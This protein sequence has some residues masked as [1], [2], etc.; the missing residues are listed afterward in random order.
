MRQFLRRRNIMSVDIT[1]ALIIGRLHG[2]IVAATVE[3]IV[4]SRPV[5]CSVYTSY[6][7]VAAIGDCCA[8]DRRNRR[9]AI[10]V[11]MSI[12][13]LASKLP[14]VMGTFKHLSHTVLSCIQVV[15]CV[16]TTSDSEQD[17]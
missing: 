5:A 4:A 2:A 14:D 3:A 13:I 6:E 9:Q 11:G 15:S 17:V 7:T 1:R 12:D 8:D 10:I 16:H